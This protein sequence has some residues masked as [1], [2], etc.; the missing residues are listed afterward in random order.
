MHR[1]REKLTIALMRCD[2]HRM[3]LIKRI[4]TRTS[5]HLRVLSLYLYCLKETR[6]LKRRL[7]E[8]P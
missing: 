8:L 1:E 7:K 5:R 6:R 2:E 3:E 4:R